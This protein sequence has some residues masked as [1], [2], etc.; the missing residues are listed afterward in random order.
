MI[1]ISE[2]SLDLNATIED[3]LLVI[4]SGA[5]KIALVVDADNKFIG[6]S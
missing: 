5:V 4:D 6:Y 3:A 1:D 2:I